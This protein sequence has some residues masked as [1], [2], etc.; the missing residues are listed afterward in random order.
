MELDTFDRLFQPSIL[1]DLAILWSAGIWA[2]GTVPDEATLN[3][4]TPKGKLEKKC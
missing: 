2:N 4:H 1:S 3:R